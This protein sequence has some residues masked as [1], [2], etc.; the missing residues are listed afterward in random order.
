VVPDNWEERFAPGA[1]LN[2]TPSPLLVE[3]AEL[4]A[5]G[6]A[7]DLAC[8]AG[9][10][11]IYLASL[12]W[13]VLAVDS[14]PA[15]LGILRERA[16]AGGLRIDARQADLEGGEFAIEPASFDLI[17]DFLYLQRNLFPQIREGLRPGGLF[18]AEILVRDAQPHRFALEPGELREEFA[19]WKILYYSEAARAGQKRPSAR[20]L[21]R[22]A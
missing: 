22:R 11:A 12:G 5:P 8:G 6:R 3:A 10:N 1:R 7:L 19:G 16:A 4:L 14:S 2:F 9:R 20:I 18:A 13:S 21:A 17:C 15:A